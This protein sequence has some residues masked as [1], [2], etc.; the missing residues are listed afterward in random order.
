MPT[1]KLA[2]FLDMDGVLVDLERGLHERFNY[3]FPP[4]RIDQQVFEKE[5]TDIWLKTAQ[6]KDF[7]YSLR[8]MK[9][10]IA[11]YDYFYRITNPYILTATPSVFSDP[12]HPVERACRE[13][14][15]G[16]IASHFSVEQ[17][18]RMFITKSTKKQEFMIP[19]KI[20]VLIDDLPANI[21]RWETAGGIGILYKG[22]DSAIRQFEERVFN[23]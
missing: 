10:Y 11:L 7:W 18:K 9:D 17:S 21:E 13:Q 23:K 19:G 22:Y 2:V 4:N 20:N 14:K 1:S 6:V 16:W 3:A 8:P 15:I 5:I 12:E